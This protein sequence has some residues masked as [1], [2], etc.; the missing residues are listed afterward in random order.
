MSGRVSTSAD[1]IS[2]GAPIPRIKKA[3]PL[4]GRTVHIVWRSGEEKTVDL[5]PVF[6]SRRIYIPLR[7][8]EKLFRSL[9]VSRHGDSLEWDGGIDLSAVWIEQLPSTEFKNEDFRRAMEA[10]RMTLEGMAAVLEISRRQVAD[11]RKHKPIPRHIALATRYL[12]E[13][14]DKRDGD[15]KKQRDK[16][17]AS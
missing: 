5:M 3:H 14:H 13:R 12:M 1:I 15:R 17:A 2:V 7:T 8:N 16:V 10:L 6:A 4:A 9:R 11:Y